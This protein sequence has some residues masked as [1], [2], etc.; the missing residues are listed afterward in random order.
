MVLAP[1]PQT[2]AT[3]IRRYGHLQSYDRGALHALL[4]EALVAHVA[5]VRDETAEVSPMG[6]ARDGESLLLHGSTRAGVVTGSPLTATVTL[7]DGLVYA[8][9]LY[10]STFNFRSAVVVGVPVVV[11]GDEKDRALRVLCD[12]LMP[13]RWPQVAPLTRQ[14]L[15]ATRVLRLPF[16]RVSLKIRSGPPDDAEPGDLWT[17]HVPLAVTAAAPQSQPG[18]TATVPAYVTAVSGR[19][20]ELSVPQRVP[21]AAADGS[22]P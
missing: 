1:L 19:P 13:G 18:C 3:R 7:L 21:A 4:D 11:D 22:R 6:F 12:K 10:D 17:G 20:A 14:Q 16:D 9:T 8:T 5:F 2:P 15:A